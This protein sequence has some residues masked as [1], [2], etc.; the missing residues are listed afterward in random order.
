MEQDGLQFEIGPSRS[1]FG[2]SLCQGSDR[3]W[4]RRVV[5]GVNIIKW[6]DGGQIVEFKVML[7]PLR[8]INVSSASPRCS[9]LASRR[10]DV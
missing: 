8:A 10:H 7:R 4:R 2:S 3:L 1:L 5:N 6:N 9:N